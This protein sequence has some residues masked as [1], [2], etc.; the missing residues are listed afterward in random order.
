MAKKRVKKTIYFFLIFLLPFSGLGM[1]VKRFITANYSDR[2][3][4][5]SLK[6]DQFTFIAYLTL[7]E[8]INAEQLDKSLKRSKIY[9]T[10]DGKKLIFYPNEIFCDTN[11]HYYYHDLEAACVTK[12]HEI[13]LISGS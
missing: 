3:E 5:I 8:Q 2:Q 11:G 7:T 13:H 12:I 1:H 9:L 4:V 6:S 10:V